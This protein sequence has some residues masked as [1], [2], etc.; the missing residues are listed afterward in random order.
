MQYVVLAQHSADICP[1]SNAKVRKKAMDLA[2]QVAALTNKHK[3][4]L[5]SGPHVLGLSHKMVVVVDAPSV[6]AVRD[7]GMEAGLVQWNDVEIH[8][9]WNMEEAL[10]RIAALEP[11]PW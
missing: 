11:I 1:S 4:K 5:V 6:E 3:V 10:K 7:F 2:G 8:P 9:S